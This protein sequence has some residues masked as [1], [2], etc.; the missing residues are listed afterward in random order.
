[1]RGRLARRPKVFIPKKDSVESLRLRVPAF[2]PNLLRL[3]VGDDVSSC[4]WHPPSYADYLRT[5]HSNVPRFPMRLVST[6][7]IDMVAALTRA[8]LFEFWQIEQSL[9]IGI[10]CCFRFDDCR[11]EELI[12][13]EIN[14]PA[15]IIANGAKFWDGDLCYY[16][17]SNEDGVTISELFWL[18]TIH[19]KSGF[20]KWG[21]HRWA[22]REVEAW[23]ADLEKLMVMYYDHEQ[24]GFC[25][26]YPALESTG[27]NRNQK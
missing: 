27:D 10:T 20:V 26:V 17:V 18:T 9:D 22:P 25:M 24:P 5:Y 23:K 16:L 14:N 6:H 3:P 15:T 1:M 21:V 4:C 7:R 2:R 8:T 11:P 12:K 13:V 19:G